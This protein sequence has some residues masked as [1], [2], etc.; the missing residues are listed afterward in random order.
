MKEGVSGWGKYFI[1]YKLIYL[2]SCKHIL[3]KA[4]NC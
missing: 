3:D 2:Y 1:F 4:K